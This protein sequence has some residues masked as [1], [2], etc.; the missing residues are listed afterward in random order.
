MDMDVLTGT[1]VEAILIGVLPDECELTGDA[2]VTAVAE[3]VARGEVVAAP[4][5]STTGYR[6]SPEAALLAVAAGANFVKAC[7]DI[8]YTIKKHRGQPPEEREFTEK[9]QDEFRQ[10]AATQ[11]ASL[12]ENA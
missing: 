12:G 11:S 9:A 6:L 1:Q 8:Y 4:E 2:H 10:K 3:I 7:V 5:P